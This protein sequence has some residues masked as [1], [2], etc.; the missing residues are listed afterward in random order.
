MGEEG[1]SERE[2]EKKSFLTSGSFS[3]GNVQRVSHAPQLCTAFAR[4]AV[5]MVIRSVRGPRGASD[6]QK[7]PDHLVCPPPTESRERL[8]NAVN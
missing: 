1:N 6:D 7:A 2:K 5:Q 4:A 3:T 8:L